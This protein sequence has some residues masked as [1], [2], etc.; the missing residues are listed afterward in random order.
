MRILC[1]FHIFKKK[2]GLLEISRPLSFY[3]VS[4]S[5]NSVGF[6]IWGNTLLF[7]TNKSVLSLEALKVPSHE[8]V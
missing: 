1:R 2:G 6:Y 8:V 3:S 5:F 4:L 7:N